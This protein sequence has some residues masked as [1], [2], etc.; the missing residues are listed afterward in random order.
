MEKLNI[1]S[2]NIAC[3]PSC[4]NFV[5][6][7]EKRIDMIIKLIRDISPDVFCLQEVFDHKISKKIIHNFPDYHFVINSRSNQFMCYDGLLIASRHNIQ[8]SHIIS[9]GRGTGEEY[10]VKKCILSASIYIPYLKKYIIIHNTHLQADGFFS[11]KYF[12]KK[13]RHKQIET[14]SNHINR[15]PNVLNILCGDLNV[16]QDMKIFNELEMKLKKSFEFIHRNDIKFI[17]CDKDQ[18]DHII[19]LSNEQKIKMIEYY[20]NKY[21]CSDHCIVLSKITFV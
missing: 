8:K 19:F 17:T 7:P 14:M 21:E 16:T 13:N 11:L 5:S 18:L 3:L 15:I 10:F 1:L 4:I 9:Y 12:D 6:N 2:W 20:V